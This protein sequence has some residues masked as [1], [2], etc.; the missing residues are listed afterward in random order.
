MRRPACRTLWRTLIAISIVVGHYV[1]LQQGRA[2]CSQQIG[3][4]AVNVCTLGR[5]I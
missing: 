4:E 3:G 5:H 2:I 1:A